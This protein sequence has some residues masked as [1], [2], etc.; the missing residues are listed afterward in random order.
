MA[1]LKFLYSREVFRKSDI[2]RA[3]AFF[4]RLFSSSI[5]LIFFSHSRLFCCSCVIGDPEGLFPSHSPFH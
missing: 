5:R 3:E 4:N 2:K 1:L